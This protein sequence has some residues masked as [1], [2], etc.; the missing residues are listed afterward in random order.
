MLIYNKGEMAALAVEYGFQR[1]T[2]EKVLRLK[3]VLEFFQKDRLLKEHLILK[4]GTAINLTVFV[5][6]RLSVDIDMDYVPNDAREDMLA[7]REKISETIKGYMEDEGYQLAGNSRFSHSLDAFHYRY[8]N[9]GGTQDIMKIEIN[10]SLRAHILEPKFQPILTNAFDGT[11]ELLTVHPIEI[12]AAKANALLNR[13]AARDLYDFNNLVT[14]NLFAEEQSLFRKAV[15]FYATISAETVNRHFDL[16]AIDG[17]TFAKIRRD[18]FPVLTRTEAREHFD[19][20]QYQLRVK[21]YLEDLMRLT[22]EEGEYIDRF[23]QGEYK[24]ALLFDDD[25]IVSRIINHPMAI[26]KCASNRKR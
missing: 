5:L 17:L 6:P 13:A 20:T 16:S 8:Q 19:L 15:V 21:S 2:F 11:M 18:L 7:Q 4:G 1:D 23:I 9:S 14:M 10:Y 12:F 25:L 22:P 3:K 26:W 24:P